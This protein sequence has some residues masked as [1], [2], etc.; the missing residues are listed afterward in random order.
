MA[1]VTR[2]RFV[3][4]AALGVGAIGAG[5]TTW[6]TGGYPPLPAGA[7][8]L[9]FF[10]EWQYLVMAAAGARIVHPATAEVARFADGYL[11]ALPAADQR[12]VRALIGFLEHGA[13]LLT[14]RL[15]R[16]TALD[17]AAQDEVL[18]AV[19]HHRIGKLRGGFNVVKAVAYMALYEDDTSWTAI[20]Y[21][22]PLV[23]RGAP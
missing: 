1:G 19:E 17:P 6:R 14:G 20:D 13:P 16:F 3:L 12:D 21:P 2:R 8:R 23:P 15:T 11:A 18:R 10:T 9:Q 7:S 5:L 22:G 4:W